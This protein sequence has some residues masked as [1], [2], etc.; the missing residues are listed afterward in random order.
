MFENFLKIDITK[1]KRVLAAALEVFSRE[2]YLRANT[3]EIAALAEISKGLLFHYFGSKKNLYLFLLD[4]TVKQMSERLMH[5]HLPSQ[6][7]LFEL[8]RVISVEKLRIA[9]EDPKGY[10]L[11]YEAFMHPPKGLEEDMKA[12]FS[13]LFSNSEAQISALVDE[14][15]FKP[16]VGKTRAIK[17]LMAYMRGVFEEY[18]EQ[19][20]ALT[21]EEAVGFVE[22]YSKQLFE[23]FEVFREAFYK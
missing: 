20:N 13:G 4:E 17:I 19:N 8:L 21:P 7:E 6:A 14:S 16:T 23:D 10:R 3:N 12:R 2:G 5:I 9:V 11:I 15:L 22:D 18:N 1:Q